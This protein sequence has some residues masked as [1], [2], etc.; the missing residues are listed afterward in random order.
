MAYVKL[1]EDLGGFATRKINGRIAGFEF[2][3]FAGETVSC[4]AAPAKGRRRK[5]GEPLRRRLHLRSDK[6][7][8]RFEFRG[9]PSDLIREGDMAAV[10]AVLP[11]NGDYGPIVGVANLDEDE[12]I[13]FRWRESEL[14]RLLTGERL[15][16]RKPRAARLACGATALKALAAAS[17]AY[18]AMTLYLDPQALETPDRFARALETALT[19]EALSASALAAI[20]SAVVFGLRA[21]LRL[22]RKALAQ[23]RALNHFWA[24]VGHALGYAADR[25]ESCR[26]TESVRTARPAQLA[27]PLL[28][29]SRLLPPPSQG[30]FDDDE[31]SGDR[32]ASA[33]AA[34]AKAAKYSREAAIAE[35]RRAAQQARARRLA[36]EQEKAR[37]REE[38]AQRRREEEARREEEEA[39]RIE[40]EQER[41][42]LQREQEREQARLR[43]EEEQRLREKQEARLRQEEAIRREQEM[44]RRRVE[45]EIR[46]REEEA[47]LREEQEILAQAQEE[48]RRQAEREA[49]RRAEQQARLR[50][51]ELAKRDAERA[52]AAAALARLEARERA[53]GVVSPRPGPQ[54]LRARSDHAAADYHAAEQARAAEPV[55]RAVQALEAAGR[56]RREPGASGS[57]Y[58]ARLEQL[59]ARR[60]AVERRQQERYGDE[61]V[62]ENAGG[63]ERSSYWRDQPEAID[64]PAPSSAPRRPTPRFFEAGHSAEEP[65]HPS[66]PRG[67]RSY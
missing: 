42:R 32:L 67:R 12:R 31:R 19:P 23:K 3:V 64:A 62:G 10:I 66:R 16:Y 38:E 7:D 30:A 22:T 25:R 33:S 56:S 44:Q 29:P 5:R 57:D 26:P 49:R 53:R 20:A 6:A 37:R 9:L 17:A 35:Q 51:D 48:A 45:E 63:D 46:R 43:E 13:D 40:A 50:E 15:D 21:S 60:R 1:P 4:E 18:L 47:R 52:R 2:S 65:R 41:L 59:R 11:T 55:E 34:K 54:T 24:R 8:K 14:L 58:V 61:G 28:S 27:G 39:L 36:E